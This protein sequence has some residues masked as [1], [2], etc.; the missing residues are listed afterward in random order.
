MFLD[1]WALLKLT[2]ASLLS[3]V[4]LHLVFWKMFLREKG[5]PIRLVLGEERKRKAHWR[6]LWMCCDCEVGGLCDQR[7]EDIE[8]DVFGQNKK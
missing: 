5:F 8:E 3:R 1:V 2:L 4:S 7:A 6:S